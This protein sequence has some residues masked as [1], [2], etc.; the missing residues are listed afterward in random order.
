[1]LN[2]DEFG[3]V[4]TF[5]E[6]PDSEGEEGAADEAAEAVAETGAA[7]EEAKQ[8]EAPA[9]PQTMMINTSAATPAPE[10]PKEDDKNGE[11]NGDENYEQEALNYLSLALQIIGDFSAEGTCL[12]AQREDRKRLMTF[13]EIDSL[14]SRV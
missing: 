4:K 2:T 3:N 6:E 9:A 12:E 5:S 13:L 7:Q 11:A 8:E 10:A 14:L 1:M